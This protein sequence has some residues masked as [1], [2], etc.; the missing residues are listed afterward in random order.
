MAIEV[1][2]FLFDHVM[3]QT[4]G[5]HVHQ[6]WLFVNVFS[7]FNN[8]FILAS[9]PF[10]REVIDTSKVKFGKLL[11][12][13]QWSVKILVIN[14]LV[15]LVY[16]ISWMLKIESGSTFVPVLDYL[17]SLIAISA[18]LYGA[19]LTLKQVEGFGGF[20]ILTLVA[21]S[22][23]LISIQ[24]I[25]FPALGIAQEFRFISLYASHIIIIFIM[26][27]TVLTNL[28]L[29]EK[30]KLENE[31]AEA[32]KTIDTLQSELKELQQD[33][34]GYKSTYQI[35]PLA[36]GRYVK[37]YRT[38]AGLVVEL[39][40]LDKGIIGHLVRCSVVNREYKDMLRFAI[41]KRTGRTIKAHGGAHS[42]FGDI[43]K[44]IL[45]IRNRLINKSLKNNGHRPLEANEL[46]LQ[47]IKGSGVFELDCIA[48]NI[49]IDTESLSQVK[50]LREMLSLLSATAKP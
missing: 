31:G 42:G 27:L 11:K 13:E 46:I 47:R 16:L 6:K 21:F 48:Q 38:K 24:Y 34:N 3:E 17:Y 26:V 5:G 28:Y 18:F 40:L 1:T 45:D 9:V 41:Y 35:A 8:A 33:M 44:S 36:I 20:G 49:E 37:F 10:F 15:V 23:L 30:R 32:L 50:E 25:V 43:Y 2:R 12:W 19:I 22:L 29:K 7:A 39:T 4:G 14:S